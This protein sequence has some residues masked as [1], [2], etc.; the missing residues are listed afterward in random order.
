M[1]DEIDCPHDTVTY[2]CSIKS[3]T[4]NLYLAWSVTFP[5]FL[6]VEITYDSSNFVGDFDDLDM[7]ISASLIDYSDNY[8]E[9]AITLTVQN[10]DYI[11]S[12]TVIECSIADLDRANITLLLNISGMKQA[13][14]V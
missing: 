9:S 11:T 8:I 10:I 7:N 1:S 14:Y 5:E 4:E 6:P 13:T 3:N 2:N 12:G